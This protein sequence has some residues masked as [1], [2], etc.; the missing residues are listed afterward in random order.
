M[1]DVAGLLAG[2]YVGLLG[3]KVGATALQVRRERRAARPAS[4]GTVTILQPIL[5]GDAGLRD[6]L[7]DNANA[8]PQAELLWL[9]DDDDARAQALAR[10]LSAAPHVRVL[11][12]PPAPD[13]I[14][15]KTFK[16]DLALATVASEFVVVLDDDARLPATTL[17]A[18]LGALQHAELSTALPFYRDG[19]NLPARLLGQFVNNNAALTYL[20][21]L[22]LAAPV[23]INGMCYALRTAQLR[24]L[25]SFA[26]LLRHLTDDLAIADAVRAGG[27]RI[28]QLAAPVEMATEVP[29]LARYARQMHRWMLFATLLLRRQ[30]LPMNLL[31]TVLHG[32]HPLLLWALLLHAALRPSGLAWLAL[33]LVIAAR[34]LALMLLQ[35]QLTGGVRHRALLSLLAEL[36]QP[37]HL[38]HAGLQRTITW[39]TRRYRVFDNHRFT[40]ASARAT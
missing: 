35:R 18:L 32:L 31:I 19:T 24:A 26:P 21:L 25:G 20:P 6:A 11:S 37:L 1:S 15:P 22:P 36:L 39:R 12:C 3:L 23:T 16:L 5:A 33:G 13:G 40:A 9:I 30:S 29:D 17:H 10:E 34:A 8:L 14:N 2:A 7:R 28:A 27:G 4:T 38:L